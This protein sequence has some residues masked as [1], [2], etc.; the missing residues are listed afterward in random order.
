MVKCH[1]Q[2]TNEHLYY[3]TLYKK[4]G[5]IGNYTYLQMK[6]RK[7]N[8]ETTDTMNRNRVEKMGMVVGLKEWRRL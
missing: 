2:S 4:E 5:R 7:D 3:I 8:P 6:Y 1:K